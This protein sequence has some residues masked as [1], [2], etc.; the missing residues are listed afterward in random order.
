MNT[1]QQTEKTTQYKLIWASVIDPI[2]TMDAA[3]WVDTS[4]ELMGMGWHVDLIGIGETDTVKSVRGMDV[5]CY[6]APDIYFARKLLY[7]AKI[8]RFILQNWR[9][10]DVV[11]FHQI[12]SFWIMPLK[13]VRW[14]KRGKK[15]LFVMDTRDLPDYEE[16]NWRV[17]LHLRSYWFAHWLANRFADFQIAI[18]D[19]MAEMVEIPHQQLVGTWP[20]GVETEKF[21]PFVGERCWPQE[22]EPIRLIYIGSLLRKR[23]P[24]ALS[25][26]VLLAN[27][28]G[29]NFELL[30]YG[31]GAERDAIE[32]MAQKSSGAIRLMPP[33]P[34]DEVPKV[35]AQA[36]VGVTS[37]PETDDVK[38]QASSPVKLFEY[39]AVGLPIL[40]TSNYCHT[41]VVGNGRYAF[42]VDQPTAP[43]I[44]TALKQIW[45]KRNELPRLSQEALQD[46]P[47]W[48]WHS[49]AAKLKNA[50]ENAITA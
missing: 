1:V 29:M 31:S 26:A 3:T 49:A 28:N 25:E 14:F 20:S 32:Q 47:N 50:L 33:V 38:Y 10:V 12:S 9:D 42:W 43:A 19:K 13:I 34:H 2:T 6:S 18:T 22:G 35:L 23:N 11:M 48:T 16:G 21:T 44:E 15:T 30:L 5:H 7:H 40:A 4:R 46:A 36:H 39:M 27:Q 24:V 8:V 37:L 41:E 45:E 17:Q